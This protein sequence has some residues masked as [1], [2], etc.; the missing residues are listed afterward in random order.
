MSTADQAILSGAVSLTRPVPKATTGAA[1]T[2]A[3]ASA[4]TVIETVAV[5]ESSSP[6]LTKKVNESAPT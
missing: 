6:S 5:L 1:T 4:A 2:G 3:A